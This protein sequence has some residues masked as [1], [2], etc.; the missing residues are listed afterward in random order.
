[1]NLCAQ[2]VDAW[3]PAGQEK[4]VAGQLSSSKSAERIRVW[5]PNN[6]C[7]RISQLTSLLLPPTKLDAGIRTQYE[8]TEVPLSG[9][10]GRNFVGSG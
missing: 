1:M 2:S 8:I 5:S 4:N 6:I 7:T 3:L 10:V 9:K